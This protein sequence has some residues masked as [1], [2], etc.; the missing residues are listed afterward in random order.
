MKKSG[1][2]KLKITSDAFDHNE[3]IPSN[4]TCE[5]ENFNPPLRIDHIPREAVC[6]AIIVDDPDAPAGTFT[7]WVVWNIPPRPLIEENTLTGGVEGLNDYHKHNFMGSCPPS[8]THRYFFKVYALD[9]MLQLD[10]KSGK[11]VLE[12]AMRGKVLAYGELIGLYEKINL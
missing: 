3:F 1:I 10:P 12:K 2:G 11:D 5:G 9:S 8:G 7:H 4:Y 6:L